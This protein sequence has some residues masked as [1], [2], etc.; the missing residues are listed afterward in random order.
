MSMAEGRGRPVQFEF[1]SADATTAA[2]I[3]L[4][5]AG[6]AAISALAADE[7]LYINTV[8]ASLAAAVLHAQI[9]TG[10]NTT[11]DAGEMLVAL[12]IGANHVRFGGPDYGTACG[13]GQI[14]NVIA[15][16]AGAIR[17]AGTGFI[18]KG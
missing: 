5:D 8:S 18:V 7:T 3:S 16:V 17:I 9:F 10:A 15:S 14:P 2:A 12:G 13:K 11:L 4:R 6:G 1:S